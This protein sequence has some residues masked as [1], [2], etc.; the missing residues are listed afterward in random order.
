[1]VSSRILK[2]TGRR[3]ARPADRIGWGCFECMERSSLVDCRSL[4]KGIYHT[5]DECTAKTHHGAHSVHRACKVD[6]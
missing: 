1:M 4:G 2:N 6:E 3:L 5:N